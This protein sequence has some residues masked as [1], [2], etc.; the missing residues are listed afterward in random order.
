MRNQ[1]YEQHLKAAEAS[2]GTSAGPIYELVQRLCETHQVTGKMLDFGAGIGT[3]LNLLRR[4]KLPVLPTGADIMARPADLAPEINWL[5]G[6]LNQPLQVADESFD[7]VVSSE[8]IEHL[9]NPRA[10]FRDL[11]RV[12][13]PG[14]RL[15]LTTPNQESIRSIMALIVTGHFM[16]FM[17]PSYPAHITALLR[18]DFTRICLE[19]GFELPE[20]SFT[21]H[22]GLPK[23]GHITWQSV[24]LGV[25]KGILFSDNMAVVTRKP[26]GG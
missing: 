12:L 1:L 14:G 26:I 3:L 15:I 18:K 25:L 9:E 22:G 20:F 4:K 21:N 5:Q 6:D 2:G 17:D 7:V 19:V 24:S 11:F 8:V 10:V 13:K 16:A 23:A